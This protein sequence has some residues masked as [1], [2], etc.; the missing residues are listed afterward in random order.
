MSDIRAEWVRN[1]PG[2]AGYIAPDLVK[3]GSET[4]PAGLMH[5]FMHG[6]FEHWNGFSESCDAINIYTFRRDVAQFMLDFR[7]YDQLE[8]PNPWENWRPF[9]S[10]F[11]AGIVRD[12]RSTDG[13]S[14][15]D[16][17]GEGGFNELWGAI[18]HV[19]ETEIPAIVAGKLSL[20]PPP[21]QRYFEAFIT[22]TEETRWLDELRW[23]SNLNPT[24]LYLW[25][26]A[27]Q[28]QWIL[29]D[30]PEIDLFDPSL[31]TT[32]PDPLR[33]QLR[34]VDR[35]KLIDFVNTLE[36]ISCSQSCEKLWEAD[37][38]FWA[39]YVSANLHRSQFYL[40]ELSTDIGIELEQSN[41]EAIQQTLGMLVSDL[42]CG[43]ASVAQLRTSINAVSDVSDLQKE[44]LL[45]MID[46]PERGADRWYVDCVQ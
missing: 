17:F 8:T 42:Y 26:T 3:S 16:L 40:D 5:E 30:S 35:S 44:A 10:F 6:Y 14:A 24:D 33:Q 27:F 34:N 28:H 12:Y 29:V 32:I 15:W 7:E 18:Y 11:H 37:P 25:D 4:A 21:L 2:Y 22:E 41:L 13:K 9:Y 38:G 19:A 36:D 45:Q 46:A 1:E 43:D 31:T 20:I 39:F 23:Y